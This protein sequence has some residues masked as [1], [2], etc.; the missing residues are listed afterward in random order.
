L[1]FPAFQSYLFRPRRELL[2]PRRFGAVVMPSTMRSILRRGRTAATTGLRALQ[3]DLLAAAAA[4]AQ[5]NSTRTMVSSPLPS[6]S[7]SPVEPSLKPWE[8][9]FQPAATAVEYGFT[10]AIHFRAGDAS[11]LEWRSHEPVSEY[12]RYAA[13]VGRALA[14]AAA[15]EMQTL[16]PGHSGSSL[17]PKLRLVFASDSGKARGQIVPIA[18]A[19]ADYIPRGIDPVP[20][21]AFVPRQQVW[22]LL[23]PGS[24]VLD[25]L[26]PAL[27]LTAPNVPSYS[28]MLNGTT[29]DPHA[30]SEVL[31]TKALVFQKVG[32]PEEIAG[33]SPTPM[34]TSSGDQEEEVVAGPSE[35]ARD[36]APGDVDKLVD[37]VFHI[38]SFIANLQGVKVSRSPPASWWIEQETRHPSV[39]HMTDA[40]RKRWRK[41][42]EMEWEGE[43]FEDLTDPHEGSGF[44]E[45]SVT[46]LTQ[47][48]RGQ[49]DGWGRKGLRQYSLL[50]NVGVFASDVAFDAHLAKLDLSHMTAEE[51]DVATARCGVL[52]GCEKDDI[53]LTA[54][55]H[56]YSGAASLDAMSVKRN[57]MFDIFEITAGAVVDVWA[58]AHNSGFVGTCLSQISRISAELSYA[59]GLALWHPIA[60]DAE[61]CHAFPIPHPYTIMSEWR[62]STRTLP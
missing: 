57:T 31:L 42:K 48:D 60:M 56:G 17:V 14:Q 46:D 18:N 20:T 1:W 35:Y 59:W 40:E 3:L 9:P 45:A 6:P 61:F 22:R 55:S 49:P 11:I 38:E 39:Q 5:A 30:F 19:S 8:E 2:H 53:Y 33:I 50:S 41:K 7:D 43:A 29:Y 34:P 23:A 36:V 32:T 27:E 10:M 28:I 47:T 51:Q 21:P 37:A 44:V 52:H 15:T 16:L 13:F 58:L 54:L 25:G 4:V 62:S 26:R 24:I 12:A